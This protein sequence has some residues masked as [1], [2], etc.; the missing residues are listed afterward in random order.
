[1]IGHG[2]LLQT[3]DRSLA[4]QPHARLAA[5]ALVGQHVLELADVGHLHG[6]DCGLQIGRDLV[7]GHVDA[8]VFAG[9]LQDEGVDDP[10]VGLA[11]EAGQQLLS[12]LRSVAQERVGVLTHLPREVG[13]HVLDLV[14]DERWRIFERGLADHG[15]HDRLAELLIGLT[16]SLFAQPALDSLAQIVIGLELL[17]DLHRKVVIG[18]GQLF[19]LHVVDGDGEGD[20]LAGYFCIVPIV[21]DLD[22]D[23]MFLADSDADKALSQSWHADHGAGP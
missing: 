9:V 4:D 1:M 6:G 3:L 11:A 23:L 18:I 22:V 7:V 20:G 19:R 14:L 12:L 17:R 16:V 21:I 8:E 10:L 13:P 2:D 5:D 15:L